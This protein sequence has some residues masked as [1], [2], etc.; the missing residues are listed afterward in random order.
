MEKSLSSRI[1]RHKN[2]FCR[3]IG[4]NNFLRNVDNNVSDYTASHW[5]GRCS[6]NALDF[7]PIDDA[8]VFSWFSSVPPYKFQE[9]T[10]IRPLSLSNSF[11]F[12]INQVFCHL[13][14]LGYHIS[15]DIR[16]CENLKSRWLHHFLPVFEIYD[17]SGVRSRDQ[18]TQNSPW[19]QGIK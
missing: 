5:T 8:Q 11:R 6:S 10:S 2:W 9:S 16:R 14:L 4:S 1:W 12:V 13:M 18:R 15:E 3:E 17:L 19:N 7:Y